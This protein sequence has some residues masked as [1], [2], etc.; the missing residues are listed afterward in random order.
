[1]AIETVVGN[2]RNTHFWTDTWLLGQNLKQ[3]LPHLFS[4]IVVRA[5]K[6]TMYDAITD[7]K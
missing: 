4:V 2:G 6:R 7:G 5:R 3:A 1:M